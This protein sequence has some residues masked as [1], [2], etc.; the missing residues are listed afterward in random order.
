M[1]LFFVALA[2]LSLVQALRTGKLRW[3]LLFAAS[4]ALFLLSFPGAL[5]VALTLNLVC[6]IEL[7]CRRQWHTAGQ[8]V[9]FNFLGAVPVLQLA[10]PSAPQILNFLREEQP[11]YVTDVWLWLHDL[12]SVLAIGWQYHNTWP[13]T[14][15]GKDWLDVAAGSPVPPMLVGGVLGLALITGVVLACRRGTPSRLIVVAPVLAALVS[16]AMN[17]RPGSPMTVWYLIYLLIPTTL[18]VFLAVEGVGRWLKLRWLPLVLCAGFTLGYAFFTRAA[19]AAV[20]DHARQPT[21]ET[22]AFIRQQ[23]PEAMTVTFGVSDRQ[24]SAYDHQVEELQSV[25]DLED[26]MARSRAASKP[27]YVYY[28]SDEHGKKR[29]PEIYDRVVNS[30]AFE[31]VA[32]FPGSEEL[33][34]Y[35]V[36]RLKPAP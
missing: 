11:A 33:W 14:H 5:Y 19:A 32:E 34:S 10:L 26:V 22:V 25:S 9:A 17:L 7:C 36:Y 29:R 31:K 4:E 3:W 27:L 35:R 13:G 16:M 12:G 23:S 18:A 1:M 20:R 28:C 24:H 30:G 15:T 21:R 2:L 8:L 6:L